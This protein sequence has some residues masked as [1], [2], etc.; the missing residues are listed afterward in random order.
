MI[1]VAVVLHEVGGIRARSLDSI[2]RLGG[3][4]TQWIDRGYV[5]A[6]ATV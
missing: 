1:I 3:G 6:T 4:V 5:S 2:H